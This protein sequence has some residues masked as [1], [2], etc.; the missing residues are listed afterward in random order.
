MLQRRHL[1]T[2]GRGLVGPRAASMTMECMSI[3]LQRMR[4]NGQAFKPGIAGNLRECPRLAE[5]N[6]IVSADALR[7]NSHRFKTKGLI[8]LQRMRSNGQAFQPGMQEHLCQSAQSVDDRR[9]RQRPLPGY[10]VNSCPIVM[11]VSLQRLGS[12]HRAGD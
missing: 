12:V 8:T 1:A 11:L 9:R 7:P 5:T 2:A 10:G 3:R 6:L 4:S